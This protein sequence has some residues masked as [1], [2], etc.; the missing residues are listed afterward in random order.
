MIAA[1]EEAQEG[2]EAHR[3]VEAEAGTRHS[4]MLVFSRKANVG[5]AA[6]AIEGEAEHEAAI[7]GEEEVDQ[8]AAIAEEEEVVA[9]ADS[10]Q[11]AARKSSSCVDTHETRVYDR[12]LT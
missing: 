2:D 11:R 12:G 6:S 8:E 5:Q 9:E 4:S 10:A 1:V 7:A 3:E